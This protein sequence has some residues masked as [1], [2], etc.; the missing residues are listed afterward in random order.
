MT[1]QARSLF[2]HMIRSVSAAAAVLALAFASQEA[3]AQGAPGGPPPPVEVAK[4]VVKEIRDHESFTGRFDAIESVEIRARVEGALEKVH[5]TDGAIVKKG[6]LLFTIDQRPYRLAVAQAEGQV[7]ISQS[8]VQFAKSD[9]DRA[10]ALRRT[11]NITEQLVEQRRQ[12]FLQAQAELSSNQAA[13]NTAKLNLEFTEVRAPVSGKMSRHLISEG[14]LVNA[15]TTLLTTMVSI[16]PIYFYF[17]FDERSFLNYSRT[18]GGRKGRNAGVND[19]VSVVLTDNSLPPRKG[20][21]DFIDNRV[22]QATG[23]VQARALIPN[24]DQFL[25]PGL[26][27]R[28]TITTSAP[29]KGVLIPDEAIVTDQN[30][31]L[32]YAVGDDGTVKPLPITMGAKVDGYRVVREGLSGD[33]KIVVNGIQRARPGQKVTPKET[34]L[35]PVRD[36]NSAS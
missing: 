1:G 20:K 26:F 12:S 29:Y 17:D 25:V 35:P 21:L 32:V 4:P 34:T 11:N 33:E 23:T 27:G 5:F 16:D 15:N 36:Q 6:D 31:R 19:G 2:P 7:G 10:D 13:L 3:W 28:I 18:M 22:D 30:R 24:S 14:N 9:L 8:R